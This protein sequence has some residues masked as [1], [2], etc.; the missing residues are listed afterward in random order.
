MGHDLLADIAPEHGF[1]DP[2]ADFTQ[3]APFILV[4]PVRRGMLPKVG[5]QIEQRLVSRLIPIKRDSVV[6]QKCALRV[7]Q[8]PAPAVRVVE[9]VDLQPEGI[10]VGHQRPSR[11]KATI[12]VVISHQN[13]LVT[14]CLVAVGNVERNLN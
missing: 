10:R 3:E 9:F 7:G 2:G 12:A 14:N 13:G 11:S 8:P 6:G 5:R 4:A 1:P